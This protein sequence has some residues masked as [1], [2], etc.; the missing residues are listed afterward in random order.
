[1]LLGDFI[2]KHRVAISDGCWL[3]TRGRS[4]TGY[5]RVWH[6]GSRCVAHRVVYEI[7]NG[8]I[9][10]GMVVCHKCDNPLCCNPNHLFIGTQADNI[11]DMIAKGRAVNLKGERHGRAK[12]TSEQARMIR[13]D[14]RP[15]RIIAAHYGI[16]PT[17]VSAIQRRV[18]WRDVQ[19]GGR[20]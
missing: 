12:V 20:P 2:G 15:Q 3:W 11:A 4:G 10:I 13:S 16:A 6:G 8:P 7:Q 9:P 19:S 17:T 5:G 14:R 18:N 1:M